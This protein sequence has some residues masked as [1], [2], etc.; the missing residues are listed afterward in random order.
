MAQD[1]Y[2]NQRYVNKETGWDIGYP[3]TPIKEYID[4]LTDKT[5]DIL[6]PGG[7][8]SY[9]AEYIYK[10]G[11]SNVVVIDI[12]SIPLQNIQSRVPEFP[13]KQLINADFFD[14]KGSYDL[15]IEQTFFC[16]L[17]PTLRKNWM[18]QMHQ[19]LKTNG[20]VVGLMFDKTFS[21]EGPPHGGSEAEYRQLFKDTFD[22]E[23]MTTAYNSIPSR[24][25]TELFVKLSKKN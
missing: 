20:K 24:A 8:N 22:I 3:S 6:V 5:I 2:W 19:L 4:Q 17:D 23:T 12:A 14:H 25:G 1:N 10:Q 15:I 21:T 11:F 16:A 9:E 13:T 18:I 7:G